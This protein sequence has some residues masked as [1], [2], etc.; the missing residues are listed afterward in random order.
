M[1]K[2]MEKSLNPHFVNAILSASLTT[3]L[4]EAYSWGSPSIKQK[5]SLGCMLKQLNWEQKHFE[6]YQSGENLDSL[7]ELP[8]KM[9]AMMKENGS[10]SKEVIEI[11]EQSFEKPDSKGFPR[12]LG[13][14]SI[15]RLSALSIVSH[16]F[17]KK[18]SEHKFDYTKKGSII[19]ELNNE[20]QEGQF[21]QI[22]EGVS[23]MIAA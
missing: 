23:R 6:I 14:G 11:V 2:R 12:G 18:L 8:L 19:D 16:S 22:M 4:V 7:K 9:S 15:G 3:C 17:I 5:V 1:L 10:F 13:A 20:Y 21:I